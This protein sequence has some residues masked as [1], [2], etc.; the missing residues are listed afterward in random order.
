MTRIDTAGKYVTTVLGRRVS[1]DALVLAT[2]SS[3]F[4]PPMPATTCRT[5]TSTAPSTISTRS[6]RAPCA[7]VTVRRAW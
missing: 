4:V 7:R 1:Y 3:A 5:A 6:G 2:G